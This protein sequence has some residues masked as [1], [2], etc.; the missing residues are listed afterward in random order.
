MHSKLNTPPDLCDLLNKVAAKTRD[1][2][3]E[4]AIQLGIKLGRIRS[5]K[6]EKQNQ[7]IKCYTEVFDL[8]ESKGSPPYTW[9]TIINA[10]RS[11]AVEEE[12]LANEL[13]EWL[14]LSQ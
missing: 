4:V 14:L 12:R 1:K 7:P 5:I 11:P 6:T 3:E 8:W 2:F 9:A 10:L 13:E